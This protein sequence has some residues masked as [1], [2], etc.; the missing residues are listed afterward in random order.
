MGL[1][2]RE[3]ETFEK[4]NDSLRSQKI[5]EYLPLVKRVV[6]RIAVYLP[7]NIEI[8]DLINAGVIG[9]MNAVENYDPTRDNKFA[10]YAVFRIRGEVLSELRSRDFLSRSSRSKIRGLENAIT[11]LEHKF[12]REV[13]DEEAANELGIDLDEF[14]QIRTMSNM[15][16]ISFEEMGC[17]SQDEKEDLVNYL[18]NSDT[19]DPSSLTRVKEIKGFI[20]SAI[21]ELKEKEKMVIS[22]YY[23]DELTMKEIG[24][25]LNI[26]ESRVSQIHSQAII[27][28]RAKLR[29][30]GLAEV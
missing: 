13:R 1:A 6:H 22:L 27:H 19:R 14:Y 24:E 16:F 11:K 12:G 29:R 18:V 21:A 25:V 9:L 20:A 17:F 28:L 5:V 7:E 15:S 10:T 2:K 3:I 26:T 30:K 23:W 4:E 8:D